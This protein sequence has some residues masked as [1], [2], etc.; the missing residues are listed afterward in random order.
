VLHYIKLRHAVEAT[1]KTGLGGIVPRILSGHAAGAV[2]IKTC[3]HTVLIEQNLIAVSEVVIELLDR[4]VESRSDECIVE[5]SC[6]LIRN[7]ESDILINRVCRIAVLIID[8]ALLCRIEEAGRYISVALLIF[9][10]AA[11][12]EI[13]SACC[14]ILLLTRV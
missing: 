9:I 2:R 5:V 11:Y 13:C 12:M 4:S 1:V 10:S 8:A 3:D 6:L 7:V 14:I